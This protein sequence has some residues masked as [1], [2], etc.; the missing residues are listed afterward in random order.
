MSVA[1]LTAVAV[2]AT[3]YA[4]AFASEN[5][6]FWHLGD[7]PQRVA[8]PV[9]LVAL[10]FVVSG[11]I[12]AHRRATGTIAAP[13]AAVGVLRITRYPVLWGV[14]TWSSFHLFANG[15]AA[16]LLFFGSFFV[17]ALAVMWRLERQQAG[18]RSANLQHY[19]EQTSVLPFAAIARGKNRLVWRELGVQ[20]LLLVLA[21]FSLIVSFHPWLFGAYPLPG[22]ND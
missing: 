11:V 19:V 17:S 7:L 22:M 2:L 14:V 8:A 18:S 15:D 1:T 5:R 6:Y 12:T 9:M 13:L 16:S 4:A 10:Y 3:Y 21:A 20:P